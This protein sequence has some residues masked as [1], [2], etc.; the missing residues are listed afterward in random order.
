MLFPTLKPSINC[1]GDELAGFSSVA[2]FLQV[3]ARQTENQHSKN[4]DGDPNVKAI[5]LQRERHDGKGDAC[6]RSG[7]QQKQ[8][9]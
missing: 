5:T 1:S 8:S 9:R 3:S 7:H 6:H 4:N 2:E